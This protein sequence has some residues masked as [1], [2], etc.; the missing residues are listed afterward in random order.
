VTSATY[1][2]YVAGYAQML[3]S[4]RAAGAQNV[5]LLGGLDYDKD[6]GSWAAYAPSDSTPAAGFSGPAWTPQIGASWHPYPSV[7]WVKSAAVESG[8]SRYAVNDTIL[9]PMPESG[10]AANSVYWQAKLKVTAVRDGA[11]TAVLPVPYVGGTPGVAGG[12][13]GQFN[14]NN[15]TGGVYCNLNLP[16]NPLAQY[17]TSGSGRGATFNLAFTRAE[18]NSG[19]GDWPNYDTWAQVAALQ[20]TRGVPVVITETGEHTGSGVSGSPWMSKL[21]SWCDANGI[22]LVA[23]SY[24][25]SPGW[26]DARGYDF[27]LALPTLT[28]GFYHTPTPGYGEFMF[29]WFTAHP[30]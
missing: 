10:S 23:Y 15:F 6:L 29:N 24:N 30:R 17:S 14:V 2:W 21:T 9:L 20:T 18:A 4:I 27:A 7:S 28:N 22:S 3:A 16:S 11:I 13:N 8:G 1:G 19:T 26:N 25:P 12:N 5:C